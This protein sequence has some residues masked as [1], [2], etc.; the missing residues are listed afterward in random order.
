MPADAHSSGLL[1]DREAGIPQTRTE[2]L[3]V[4]S[5]RPPVTPPT[6]RAAVRMSFISV[7]PVVIVAA[8]V[9]VHVLDLTFLGSG[10]VALDG[11]RISPIPVSP[12]VMA[13]APLFRLPEAWVWGLMGGFLGRR[14]HHWR[15]RTAAG[16]ELA[17]STQAVRTR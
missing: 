4:S 7:L 15:R 2:D 9:T 17:S 12:F 14:I 1:R 5:F 13:I 8:L 16:H 11:H 3:P 10:T 6:A